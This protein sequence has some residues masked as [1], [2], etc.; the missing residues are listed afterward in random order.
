MQT[1]ADLSDT[2][3]LMIPIIAVCIPIVVIW[4]KHKYSIEE[5]RMKRHG[6]TSKLA[7]EVEDLRNDVR[8]LK[9]HLHQQ[10]IA[11]DNLLANQEKLMGGAKPVEGI[12]N[13][14]GI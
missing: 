8:E 2:L 13:R 11:V 10:M 12:Q 5:L 4:T 1:I 9:D 6:E 3:A 7:T 14:L